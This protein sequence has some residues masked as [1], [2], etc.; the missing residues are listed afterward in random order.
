MKLSH[1]QYDL[2]DGLLAEYP[3]NNRDE[4]KMMVLDRKSGTIE[5]K[6]FKDLVDYFDEDDILIFNNTAI[7]ALDKGRKLSNILDLSLR[8]K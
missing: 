5:H 4:A 3:S 7:E 6:H 2:P 1:F 8:A